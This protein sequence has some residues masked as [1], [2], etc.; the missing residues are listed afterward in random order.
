[1]FY[2]INRE[3][4]EQNKFPYQLLSYLSHMKNLLCD[5]STTWKLSYFFIVNVIVMIYKI[6]FLMSYYYYNY[7]NIGKLN[8][9]PVILMV[10]VIE[11]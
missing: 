5:K 10:V 1:M 8:I 3:N 4:S 7:I 11:S 6:Y 9:T 2:E